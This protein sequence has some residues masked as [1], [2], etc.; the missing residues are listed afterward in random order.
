M[1]DILDICIDDIPSASEESEDMEFEAE[2]EADA[3][4]SDE[5]D[6]EKAEEEFSPDLELEKLKSEILTLREELKLLE[7]M[8]KHSERV[9]SE[10]NE[11]SMLFP[12]KSI[13]AIPE[14]VWE[15]VRHGSS[16]AASFALYEK[17]RSYMEEKA[18]GIN[19]KNA[20]LS[21]G[22]A[23][24]DTSC[25]YFTQEQVRAMSRA[26]VKQNYSKIRESMKK[27]N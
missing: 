14:E 24:V 9:L 6:K 23:G 2:A 13:D 1:D 17:K 11:F 25:E 19:R 18:Q 26:E 22:L 3:E 10:V 4:T 20:S 15:Q 16:L 27:W 8:K 5:T 21:A 12:E 7:D